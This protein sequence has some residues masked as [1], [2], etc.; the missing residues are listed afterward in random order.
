VSGDL[1]KMQVQQGPPVA[2]F[3]RVANEK[4]ALNDYV[5]KHLK[6]EASGEIHC[7]HCQ[8]RTK[9]SFN[10][11]YCYPCF[12]SLAQCDRCIMSPELCHF[13]QGTCREP[14]WGEQNCFQEHIVYLANS[15]GLKVGITRHNQVPIRWM[16][17][18]AISAL[19]IFSVKSRYLS[20]L[21]EVALKE[22]LADKTNWRKML[23]H[24]VEEIDLESERDRVFDLAQAVLAE[25]EAEYPGQITRLQEKPWQFAYP[26]LAWPTKIISH[27]LDKQPIVEGVLQAIKGQ[28]LIFDTGC[29]NIRKFTSYHV[30]VSSES[31]D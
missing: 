31:L 1:Q 26:S 25:L 21:I 17:Q 10:Q 16:D 9:T 14:E 19:P 2:Y 20:G 29:L 22:W 6:I 3:L 23:K 7:L 4:I 11:G 5:G 8:R 24:D 30:S 27:N 13:A 18:G 15:S 28:Y 12:K